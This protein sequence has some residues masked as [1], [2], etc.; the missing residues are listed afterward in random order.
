MNVSET[1][2]Q[3]R[4]LV[5]SLLETRF[6]DQI[7]VTEIVKELGISRSTF[8]FYYDSVFSVLQE[9]EDVFIEQFKSIDDT[10]QAVPFLDRY[11]NNPHPGIMATLDFTKKNE[12]LMSILFGRF[13][14]QNFAHKCKTNAGRAFF[15]KAVQEGYIEIEERHRKIVRLNMIG[16]HWEMVTNWAK[17]SK[18]LDVEEQAILI[19]RLMYGYLRLNKSFTNLPL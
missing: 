5:L 15:D 9:I 6:I 7:K 10:F 11:F 19:Y 4:E 14:D 17:S 1:K 18:G 8:Y 12:R 2:N 16:G 3:I 13:G